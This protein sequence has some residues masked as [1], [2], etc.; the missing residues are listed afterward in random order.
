MT[1]SQD[2]IQLSLSHLGIYVHDLEKM[3]A[4][5]KEVFE[6]TETDRGDLGHVQLIFLSRDPK[7]H[8]QFVLATGRPE[9]LSFNLINQISFRVPNLDNL[10]R[11][12]SR[13]RQHGDI[14][15]VQCVTHG[16]AVSIYCR[17]PEGN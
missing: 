14:S 15:D 8:H 11:F 4:F 16:N 3:G 1:Q 12:Y 2:N 7:E 5:Y 10:R 13:A 6:F 17:D 9:N